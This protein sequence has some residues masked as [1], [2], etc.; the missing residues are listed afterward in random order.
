MLAAKREA[1]RAVVAAFGGGGG[2][3]SLGMRV[4]TLT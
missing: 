2:G 4:W 3:L 1:L